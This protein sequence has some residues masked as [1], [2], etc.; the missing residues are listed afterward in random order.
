[1]V[2]DIGQEQMQDYVN[3]I[4]YGNRDIS[5]GIDTFWLNSSLKISA[6]QQVDFTEKLVEED[7]PFQ[8]KT[9]KTVKRIM[10]DD[11]QDE[12]TVH[13]KTGTRL[14]DTG[15]GWYVGYVE[16]DQDTWVF[17]TNVA[18]S[19]ATAKQMTLETLKKMKIV[20]E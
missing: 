7:L 10:I 1:M 16:T 15:L 11:E 9:M 18:G 8:K 5:G 12:Y 17:A 2:R 6:E 13:G 14:S 3:R 4:G 19:G 20:K